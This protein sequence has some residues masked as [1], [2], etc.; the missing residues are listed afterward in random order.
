MLYSLFVFDTCF[1]LSRQS[2]SERAAPPACLQTGFPVAPALTVCFLSSQTGDIA[3][4]RTSDAT[5]SAVRMRF[6][7]NRQFVF[8]VAID[9]DNPEVSTEHK[10]LRVC[11]FQTVLGGVTDN[12]VLKPTNFITRA[13]PTHGQVWSAIKEAVGTSIS[14]SIFAGL[15]WVIGLR[16]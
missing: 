11:N 13:Q 3:E 9:L 16:W 2:R 1:P 14:N 8:D 10:Y 4:L 7:A 15:S 5:M 12:S 6:P